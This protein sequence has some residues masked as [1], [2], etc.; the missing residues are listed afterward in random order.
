MLPGD[1]LKVA[2]RRKATPKNGD[3]DAG[4]IELMDAVVSSSVAH[5]PTAGVGRAD[6]DVPR[7]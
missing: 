1:V 7:A 2:S 4:R 5:A 6:A 3:V